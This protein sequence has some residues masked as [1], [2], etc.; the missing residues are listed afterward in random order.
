MTSLRLVTDSSLQFLARRLRFLGYD[1]A[2]APGARLEDIFELA[3]REDRT[4]LTPSLRRPARYASVPTLT[5]PRDRP[6]ETLARVATLGAPAGPPFSRCAACN[7]PLRPRT[8]FEAMGEVPGRVLRRSAALHDC[9]SCGRWYWE[10]THVVRL[11]AW[12]EQALG[13]P[14]PP[15]PG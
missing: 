13:Q 7:T 11:R 4:V 1:V 14:L 15:A 10:G 6:A 3:R 5:V 9:P 12:L 2:V 8:P